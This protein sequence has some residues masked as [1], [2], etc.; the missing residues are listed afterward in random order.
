M[1]S[2][3]V[4]QVSLWARLRYAVENR[5]MISDTMFVVNFEGDT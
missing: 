4:K 5:L 1:H 3:V 2:R